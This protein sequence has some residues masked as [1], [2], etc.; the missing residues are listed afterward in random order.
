MQNGTKTRLESAFIPEVV[1]G[2]KNS[3]N[4]VGKKPVAWIR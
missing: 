4:A 3:S 2:M 1:N